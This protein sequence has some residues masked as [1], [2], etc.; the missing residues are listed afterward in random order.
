MP[1]NNPT[2]IMLLPVLH[3]LADGNRHKSEDI[4]N[5]VSN[6]LKD[7]DTHLTSWVAF[8]FK[9]LQRAEAVDKVGPQAYQINQRGRD[10]LRQGHEK[11]TIEILKRYPEM[12]QSLHIAAMRA[13][14]SRVT[15]RSS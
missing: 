15:N 1:K 10:L 2:E 4:R 5:S 12:R 9:N 14:E 6:V 7:G 13:R 11:I 8:A 3:C